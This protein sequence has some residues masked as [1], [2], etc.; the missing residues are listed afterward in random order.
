MVH[1]SVGLP[2]SSGRRSAEDESRES[3]LKGTR[4]LIQASQNRSRERSFFPE[5]CIPMFSIARRYVALKVLRSSRLQLSLLVIG[6]QVADLGGRRRSGADVH[7]PYVCTKVSFVLRIF[8]L[9]C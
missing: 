2:G 3:K 6:A 5:S 8:R 4:E 1:M 9:S 7:M